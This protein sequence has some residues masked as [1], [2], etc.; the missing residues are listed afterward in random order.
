MSFQAGRFESLDSCSDAL[1]MDI[2]E[3]TIAEKHSPLPRWLP[4]AH[5]ILLAMTLYFWNAFLWTSEPLGYVYK[6]DFL[7]VYVGAR[8]VAEGHGSQL[9]T[10]ELQR[11]LTDTAILPYSRRI[12]LPYIYPAYVAVILSPLG[13]LPLVTAFVLWTC[14]NLLAAAWLLR[15]VLRHQSVFPGQGAV[16]LVACLAWV[17]LQLTISHGQMG[18]LCAVGLS[19]ALVSLQS[20]KQW[21]A[22]C[23]LAL[24]LVKPQIIALPLLAL[25]VW[26]CWRALASFTTIL[27]LLVGLSFAKLGYWITDY[28]HFM[29]E[30]YRRGKE[31]SLYP[32]AMQNWLGLVSALLGKDTGIAA[33]VLLGILSIGSV[34]L[35]L[36]LCRGRKGSTTPSHPGNLSVRFAIVIL[37][38]LLTSPYLYFHDWVVAVP[39]LAI[40]FLSATQWW[41]KNRCE[42]PVKILLWLIAL[43]PFVCF[44]VQFGV[45]PK[46]TP[47]QL[48]PW[49][50]A[51]LTVMGVI[52]L[53][54]AEN[55]NLQGNTGE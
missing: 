50:L 13:K 21:Q 22:G 51:I 53:Q 36:F 19:E 1:L 28:L 3:S 37:L 34:L 4:L 5:A 7:S 15:R 26:Q 46:T 47:V 20:G 23:W 25:A 10:V 33:H 55:T 49:Y 16:L 35:V 48:A 39:A 43:S 42:R 38:G 9:Y 27:V 18:L 31:F 29:K 14:I 12:L 54:R 8:A 2:A 41:Q 6:R 30:F 32:L 40:L 45:W 52:S 24:G 11:Q 44:A 17:P